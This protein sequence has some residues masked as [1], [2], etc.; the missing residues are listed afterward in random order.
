MMNKMKASVGNWNALRALTLATVGMMGLGGCNKPLQTTQ[1]AE[2]TPTP[3]SPTIT[4][5]PIA[6]PSPTM[7]KLIATPAPTI[8]SVPAAPTPNPASGATAEA[9][10]LYPDLGK[11]DSIFNRTFRDLF[12]QKKNS[13]PQSLTNFDW[14]LKLARETAQILNVKSVEEQATPTPAPASQPVQ[15]AHAAPA[16]TASSSDWLNKRIETDKNRLDQGAYD[17]RV[18]IPYP[19]YYY[20]SYGRRYWIDRYGGYHYYTYGP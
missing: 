18:A 2:A 5:A 9:L 3:T 14:P 10:R 1:P 20:D 19:Y 16:A 17:Q 4:P 8:A 6:A 11:K 12:A 13:D 7:A 15:Y